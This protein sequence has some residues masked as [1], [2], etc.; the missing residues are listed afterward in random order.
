M[1]RLLTVSEEHI[2]NGKSN[3]QLYCA[4][5]LALTD[6]GISFHGVQRHGIAFDAYPGGT[7]RHSRAMQAFLDRVDSNQ[8]VKPHTFLIQMPY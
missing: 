5:A 2:A 3:N 4:V 8:P 6:A 7:Q 1:K